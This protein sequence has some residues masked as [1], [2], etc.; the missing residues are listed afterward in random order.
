[1]L[2]PRYMAMGM[3]YDEF[4]NMNTEFHKAVREAFEERKHYRNW[5][6][7]LQASYVYD[8]IWRLSP[9]LRAVSFGKTKAEAEK[10]PDQPYPLTV[11]EAEAREEAQRRARMEQFYAQLEHESNTQLKKEVRED[12][13]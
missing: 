4:W 1:M 3:S 2:C 8:A 12:N 7:W 6:F 11:K 5:E 13:A 10:Y 9:I